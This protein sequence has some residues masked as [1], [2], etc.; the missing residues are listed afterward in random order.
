LSLGAVTAQTASDGSFGIAVHPGV[1][2]MVI[3]PPGDMDVAP[4]V[5]D[6]IAVDQDSAVIVT[7]QQARTIGATVVGP[8][9]LPVTGA[10]IE[11]YLYLT[12][13][14]VLLVGTAFTDDNGY[15]AVRLPTVG[16]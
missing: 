5:A 16:L 3:Q 14:I 10:T 4:L 12:S 7:L 15:F 11:A 2:R 9:G 8:D 6:A 13:E 1:Q